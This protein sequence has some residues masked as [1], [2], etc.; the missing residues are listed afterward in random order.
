MT[1]ITFHSAQGRLDGLAVEGHSGYADEGSD[2]VCAAISSTVGMCEC[3]FNE[4]LGLSADLKMRPDEA[5][6]TL[7]LP[8]GLSHQTE[9]TCQTL[10]TGLLVY[11]QNLSGDYPDYLVVRLDDDDEEN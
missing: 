3:I 6:L 4:V 9:H 1:T 8:G 2:I 5:G 10:L 7:R 11:L